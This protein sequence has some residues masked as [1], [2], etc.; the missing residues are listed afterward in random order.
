MT[1]RVLLYGATGGAGRALAASLSDLGSRLVLAGRSEARLA[2]L[3]QSLGL[4]ARVLLADPGFDRAIGDIRLVVNAAGPFVRTA[5]PIID[6]CLARGIDYFDIAGEWP[7]FALAEARDEIAQARGSMLLPG[8]GF[9]ITATDCLLAHAVEQF[10]ETVRLRLALSRPHRLSRGSLATLWAMNDVAV[11]VRRDGALQRRP[12][13]TLRR[14]F[15]FGT[16][17]EA[18]VAVSWPDI[19]TVQ[20]STGVPTLEVYSAVGPAGEAAI[21]IGAF[22]APLMEATG[23]SPGSDGRPR[24]GPGFV[25]ERPHRP[26]ADLDGMILVAEALDR[27]RRVKQFVLQTLDGYSVTTMTAV[28]AVRAWLGGTRRPGFQTPSSLLGS[29]FV[30]DCGA[31][32]L[33]PAAL[34][35]E[36]AR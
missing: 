35:T 17:L 15:D 18:A 8:L 27:W 1:G 6:A 32:Q 10:P 11:R 34:L 28:A 23:I 19:I 36:D 12:A 16:D 7:V 2:P 20:R 21:R 29:R 24:A 30:L 22:A 31:A 33:S 26:A 3:A 5:E 4:E 13:G 14:A 9:A 25:A